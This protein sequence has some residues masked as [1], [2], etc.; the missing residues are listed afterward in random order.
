MSKVVID[1]LV[2]RF[3][4]PVQ[5]DGVTGAYVGPGGDDAA[6]V[7]R[8]RLVEVCQFLRD[9]PGMQFNMAP[10]ITAVDYLGQE[11]RF[12]VVYNLLSTTRNWRVR[13]RVKVAEQDAV[14]P[15]VCGIWRGAN[16]F[17]RYCFDMYG[18]SLH[19]A[20]RPAPPLHVRRVRRPPA[21]QGLPAAR[22]AAAGDGARGAGGAVPR[23]GTGG[24]APSSGPFGPARPD[25]ARRG[26]M[27][28]EV[29]EAVK[30]AACAA[31]ERARR[32]APVEAH[33]GQ[34]RPVA[35]GHARDGAGGGG[36]RGREHRQLQARHRL[37]APRLREELRERHLD[38]GASRTPIGST[39]SARS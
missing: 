39:T 23:A 21:A 20:P 8:E 9:D 22:P 29:K 14:L 24:S 13:L 28:T 2:E 4:D 15:S 10:Y 27:S 36:A 25:G 3:R 7:T 18:I 11:P 38:A 35:P 6:F 37:P 16:W 26:S 30:Q 12:E 17:E 31:L 5:G 33:A 34:P 19:R 32:A 1:A